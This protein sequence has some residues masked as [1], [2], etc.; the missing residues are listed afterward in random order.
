MKKNI[1]TFFL[2]FNALGSFAQSAL[3]FTVTSVTG[4]YSITCASPTL[5]LQASTSYTAPHYFAWAGPNLLATVGNTATVSSP[6]I[7]TVV[8]TSGSV[9]ATQTIAIQINTVV[10]VISYSPTSPM[11]WLGGQT[12]VTVTAISPSLNILQTTYSSPT[13]QVSS[14]MQTVVCQPSAATV[15]THCVTD[16][17]NGCQYCIN[18]YLFIEVAG[19]EQKGSSF[20][21]DENDFIIYPNPV[22]DFLSIDFNNRSNISATLCDIFGRE[23][24]QMRIEPGQ[25]LDLHEL[26]AG[27]YT[28]KLKDESGRPMYQSK[29][30]K[31]Q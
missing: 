3:N 6:G 24:K 17:A 28:L 25:K 5:V 8:A 23:V 26:N 20:G 29:V 2:L 21:S 22:S 27:L 15:Y 30:V 7:Y 18:F 4:N 14:T 13:A 9:N 11:L 31:E 19:L 16:L 1:I 10:P 12:T